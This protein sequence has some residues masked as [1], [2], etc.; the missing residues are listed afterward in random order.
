MV[1]SSIRCGLKQKKNSDVWS[2]TLATMER[3]KRQEEERP[4]GTKRVGCLLN[5]E[6]IHSAAILGCRDS[7]SNSVVNVICFCG[8]CFCF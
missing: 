1:M 7:E 4:G 8:A 5:L 3:R 6:S 2:V